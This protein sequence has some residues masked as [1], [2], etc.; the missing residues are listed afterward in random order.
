MQV[1][2][3]LGDALGRL[4]VGQQLYSAFALVLGLTAL[5][6]TVAVASLERSNAQAE[7]LASKWLQGVGDL[8]QARAALLETRN[9]EVKFSRADDSSYRAEYQQK[10]TLAAKAGAAALALYEQRVDGAPERALLA[11]LTKSWG[12]Y[13]QA[14]Q[15]VLGL[16]RANQ[17]QDAADISDGLAST[18]ADE[19]LNALDKLTV[20]NFDGAKQAAGAANAVFLQARRVMLMLV[21]LCC[22]FGALLAYTIA[23]SIT[24]P[25]RKAVAV[26]QAVAAGDL[27]VEFEASGGN[28]A[29]QLLVALK[30]MN[31][32]LQQI[33]AQVRSGAD[34]IASASSQ[35]AAGNQ[36]LSART[37]QQASA[38]QQTAASMEELTSTVKQNADNARQANQLAICASEVAVKGG[39]VVAQ[40]VLTMDTINASSK[41]I[42]DIIGVIDGIAFQ[43]NILA[44]NAAVEAARAG[45][46]GRGFAVVASEVRSLAQRSA[47]AAKEIKGLIED[48][49]EQV[50]TG[51]KLVDQAGSTMRDIVTS[52][53]NVTDIMG[54]ITAASQEQSTG[55][56]QVSLA[57][58]QMDEVTQQNAALVEQAASAAGAL[59]E[60][61]GT[62]TRVVSVFSIDVAAPP[63]TNVSTLHAFRAP[64]RSAR[65]AATAKRASTLAVTPLPVRRR[66]APQPDAPRKADAKAAEAGDWEQF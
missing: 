28:E 8:A 44:L 53:G 19:T 31:V 16:G 41:K 50:G 34:T 3:K 42:A 66:S 23:R 30:A 15:K 5:I 25:L 60:Q 9:Y 47:A 65:P 18:A 59:L 64:Q 7:V 36:N 1:L 10:L 11:E 46:Q 4:R 27:T 26:S 13:Q 14:Q 52:I 22:A 37:E 40:V 21:G 39:T 6:G 20:F 54:E 48:S 38:L 49:V 58:T 61:A 43:T 57:I 29:A 24:L 35:I 33:V 55:I 32:S 12:A 2:L 63:T 62:L 45:E 51:A 17:R 56:E